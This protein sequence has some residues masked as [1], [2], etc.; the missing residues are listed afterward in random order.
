MN[1]SQL[2]DVL[3]ELCACGG[4]SGDEA[5]CLNTA[6]EYLSKYMPV[7]FDALG[8]CIGKTQGN[9]TGIL[10]DAHADRIGLVVTSV[11]ENGF[12][13]VSKVGGADARVMTASTVT[14]CGKEKI[15]GFVS[16]IPPHLT[17]GDDGKKA[18]DFEEVYIDI[19]LSHDE[20]VKIVTPG[21]RILF[22]G[23]QKELLNNTAVSPCIDDRAGIVVILRCLEIL[24]QSGKT[25]CPLTVNFAVQEETGGSGAQTGA[26]ASGAGEAIAVDV[27]FARAPGIKK[28]EAGEL[29][30]G[31]M[32]GFAPSLDYTMSK[33][34]VELADNNGIAY[35]YDVMGGRTGTDGDSI[36][37]VCSGIKTALIS[38][39]LK[40]MHT[41]VEVVSLDD[42][43]ACAQLMAAYILERSAENNA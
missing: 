3:F 6:A 31:A 27:G 25:I 43:E 8:N 40:N 18:S 20:A 13:R 5:D 7:E 34:L 10:L 28:E 35:Q 4:T 15:K 2:K 14:V 9:G 26:F 41:A 24:R 29:G 23:I 38:I 33:K 36:S 17:K 42:I 16:S 32:I 22:D 39:P 12:L 19:G 37:N 1:K 21:D 11:D 30:K